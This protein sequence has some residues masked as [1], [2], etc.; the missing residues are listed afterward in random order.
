MN[1]MLP[2]P[3]IADV[4]QLAETYDE[5]ARKRTQ[6]AAMAAGVLLLGTVVGGA[7][8]PIGGAVIASAEVA[9]E[10]RVKRIA[11]PTGGVISEIFVGDGDTVRQGAVLMRL[12]TSVSAVDARSSSASLEQLLAQRARLTAELEDRGAI[13]FPANLLA[14]KSDSARG[15]VAAEQRRFALNRA[16]RTNLLA[17]LRERM[18]QSRRQIDALQRQ[19]EL[20]LPELEMLRG[21]RAKGYV[22]IRRLNEMERTAIELEG[23]IGAL[24]ANIA[25]ANAAIAQ[26]QEQQVQVGQSAR[27]Q[28]SAELAQVNAAI[29]DQT[30]AS[31]DA[32]DRLERSAIRAPNAGTIDK[33]AFAAIG[34]VVRPA[35]TIMEIVPRNDRLVFNGLVSPAD[36]DRVR[37]GQ[38]TRVRLSAFNQA[39]TPELEG[40]VIFVSADPVSDT[41]TG[42]RFFR[43]RVALSPQSQQ[44][45]TRLQLVS[46]MPAELFIETGSRSMLSFITKPLMDQFAR[47]FRN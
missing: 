41:E 33:L 5:R 17:Q 3:M 45:A 16:E 42:L 23:S 15:A 19:Q 29:N 39:S 25:Q 26:A 30:V 31:A 10:S 4:A 12:D 37:L 40:E 6:I 32:G 27:T 24:Q 38:S 36:I 20:I 46:G 7:L 34:E 13:A 35:E 22:T 44:T 47:A 9:P 11:H 14:N 18:N 43:V 8:V 28:A 21:L 2:V 1:T